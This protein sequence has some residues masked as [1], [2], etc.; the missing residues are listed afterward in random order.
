ML[1]RILF[2]C[3]SV[4][5]F[6]S[7]NSF[8]KAQT[9]VL[10]GTTT[11]GGTNSHGTIFKINADGTGDTIIHSFLGYDGDFPSSTL[12]QGYDGKLYGST[13]TGSDYGVGTLFGVNPVNNGFEK[14]FDFDSVNGQR[15]GQALVWANDGLLY[16]V[17]AYGGTNGYG[18]LFSFDP[19]NQTTTTLHSFSGADGS[20]PYAGLM[21]APNGLLYGVTSLGGGPAGVLF[22]FNITTNTFTKL[23]AFSSTGGYSPEGIPVYHNGILYGVTSSGGANTSGVIYSYDIA[24]NTYSVL[25]NFMNSTGKW[26]KTG[27]IEANDGLLYG[28]TTTGAT[29]GKGCL[30]SFNLTDTTYTKLVDFAGVNVQDARGTLMQ[31][32]NGNI[33]GTS[34]RGGANDKGT[35][36]SFNAADSSFTIVYSFGMQQ[37][38][39]TPACGL[40]EIKELTTGIDKKAGDLSLSIYPNPATDEVLFNLNGQQANAIRIY[41]LQGQLIYETKNPVGNKITIATFAPGL[42]VAEVLSNKQMTRQSLVKF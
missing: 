6:S 20:V 33:Y 32:S 34:Q 16:G 7:F 30:F 41:T 8:L 4:Y 23:H 10:W 29:G 13:V 14:I 24:T 1:V 26:P 38:G 2:I 40:M 22:S 27:L 3:S 35:I 9:P 5:L 21:Q 31:A 11:A 37:S 42:Y 39:A 36:F 28:V 15:P 25:Y 18:N 12:T 19:V 17:S